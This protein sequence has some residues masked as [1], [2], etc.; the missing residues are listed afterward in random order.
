MNELTEITM[1]GRTDAAQGHAS[2][3]RTAAGACATT[4]RKTHLGKR[5][6]RP[7]HFRVPGAGMQLK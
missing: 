1:A 3:D 4:A 7:S 5:Q 2:V 6:R